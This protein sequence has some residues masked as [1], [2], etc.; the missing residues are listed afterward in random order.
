VNCELYKVSVIN[1]PSNSII[2]KKIK[3]KLILTKNKQQSEKKNCELDKIIKLMLLTIETFMCRKKKYF[4]KTHVK[5][6]RE[7]ERL[8]KNGQ[9][10]LLMDN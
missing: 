5:F 3:T 8:H 6:S 7:S 10:D 2:L 1:F 9:K 4:P